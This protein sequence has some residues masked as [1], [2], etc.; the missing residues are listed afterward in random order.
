MDESNKIVDASSIKS[1]SIKIE[2]KKLEADRKR[3]RANFVGTVATMLVGLAAVTY[4]YWEHQDKLRAQTIYQTM[5]IIDADLKSDI[6]NKTKLNKVI[7]D[8]I[9]DLRTIDE[10]IV[11]LDVERKKQLVLEDD[12][13]NK[14]KNLEKLRYEKHVLLVKSANNMRITLNQKVSERITDFLTYEHS[15]KDISRLNQNEQKK[16]LDTLLEKQRVILDDIADLINK[17]KRDR[18]PESLQDSAIK[19][20]KITQEN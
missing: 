4:T 14:L 3:R 12:F 10:E 8:Q 7:S 17:L 15:V 16:F 6:E 2:Y 9:I 1:E 20:M 5:M 11:N 13:K 18:N 19:I